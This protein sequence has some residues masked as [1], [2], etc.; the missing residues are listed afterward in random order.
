MSDEPGDE[1][2]PAPAAEASTPLPPLTPG[3]SRRW[4]R[5]LASWLIPIF[6]LVFGFGY[7]CVRE[8]IFVERQ[9][10]VAGG[11]TVK[12]GE[13]ASVAVFPIP[14]GKRKVKITDVHLAGAAQ[15]LQLV[16]A[17]ARNLKEGSPTIRQVGPPKSSHK[18]SSVEFQSQNGYYLVLELK[19]AKPGTYRAKGVNVDYRSGIQRGTHRMKVAISI[20]VQ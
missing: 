15:G 6:A 17:V 5:E 3:K 7:R 14:E 20:Q 1:L 18:L 4:P 9:D 10:T 2:E 11:V 8:P 13:I 12:P 19:A 16:T